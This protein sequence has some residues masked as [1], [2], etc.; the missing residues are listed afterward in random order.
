[1]RFT[2]KT[3]FITSTTFLVA[4]LAGGF[5]GG[6]KTF[7]RAPAFELVQNAR[8]LSATDGDTFDVRIDGRPVRV[9]LMGV[10]TPETVHPTKG[11]Q[12]F[13]AEASAETKKLE[14][15]DVRIEFLPADWPQVKRDQFNRPLA[16][17]YVGGK[18]LNEELIRKGL[19]HQYTHRGTYKHRDALRAAEK[20]AREG[21]VGMWSN[22]ACALESARK[23]R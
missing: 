9:R 2:G 17:V 3:L 8:V 14:R 16:Y 23:R 12:C 13:G 22:P 5:M 1:M 7:Y 10:D 15:T 19:A 4:G 11:A 21:G 20:E 18:L 6:Y